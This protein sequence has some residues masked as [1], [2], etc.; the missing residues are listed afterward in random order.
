MRQSH[1]LLL[2]AAAA[3]I[4][5][6]AVHYTGQVDEPRYVKTAQQDA[7]RTIYPTL[8]ESPSR[9]KFPNAV[10]T[11]VDLLEAVNIV[12]NHS[13]TYVTDKEQYGVSEHWVMNP[14]SMKGDCEDYALT[15]LSLLRQRGLP[16]ISQS[17]VV[18]LVVTN[19]T[20]NESNGHAILAVR[21][22]SGEV[23]YLDNGFDRLMTRTELEAFG[24]KFFDW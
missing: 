16:I 13:M 2:L 12:V 10:P 14:P 24:Y 1:A 19:P 20:T 3:L 6:G 17:K 21:L 9:A 5:G 4:G 11:N 8:P 22:N 7:P 18:T 23:A 15:K